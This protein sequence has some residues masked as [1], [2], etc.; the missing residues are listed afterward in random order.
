MS[1]DIQVGPSRWTGWV[2]FAGVVMFTIGCLNVIQGFVALFDEFV[3]QG[4]D[5]VQRRRLA[6]AAGLV[7]LD[8]L[9]QR[10]LG[11]DEAD[12]HRAAIRYPLLSA[13]GS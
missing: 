6:P 7:V 13:A 12:P 8:G 4:L 11:S 10:D 2:V 3:A 9:A 1:S 5:A